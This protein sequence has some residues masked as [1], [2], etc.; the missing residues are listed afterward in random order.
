MRFATT[1]QHREYFTHHHW[2]EFEGLLSQ[3]ESALLSEAGAALL[4]KHL[5]TLPKDLAKKTPME[6]YRN[7][8]DLWKEDPAIKRVSLK[9][10]F[11]EIGA[12]LCNQK[13]MRI[14]YDQFLYRGDEIP[15]LY[16]TSYSLQEI[17]SFK[18]LCIGLIIRLSHPH[19]RAYQDV[20]PL[21]KK[22]GSGVFFDPKTPLCLDALSQ[23]TL[24]SFFLIAYCPNRTFYAYEK[25]D[26]HTNV[27]K[28]E[29]YEFGDPLRNDTHPILF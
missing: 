8:R 25:N 22:V 15:S 9:S 24:A 29:G 14:A 20:L 11:A 4:A 16:K 6:L 18:S 5:K 2:I 7:G 17:S 26:P 23:E 28:K 27:L 21:P 3:E 10:Q 1:G 12:A 19:E 13:N